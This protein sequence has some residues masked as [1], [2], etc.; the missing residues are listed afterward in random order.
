MFGFNEEEFGI[1]KFEF[2]ESFGVLEISLSS[3]LD[4]NCKEL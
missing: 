2:V 3:L 1:F 4:E